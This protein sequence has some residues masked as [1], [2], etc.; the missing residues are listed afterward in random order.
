MPE[1]STRATWHADLARRD[2]TAHE[3]MARRAEQTA[4]PLL[5]QRFD[6]VTA[7][8]HVLRAAVARRDGLLRE[9]TQA[10]VERDR[11]IRDLEARL[12]R[13]PG[14]GELAAA[15]VRR[16]R[17]AVGRYVRAGLTQR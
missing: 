5:Q 11:R 1:S 12:H 17:G 10:L 3:A 8:L 2:R 6:A 4:E 15:L 9:L 14:A 16:L 13:Q 7:E